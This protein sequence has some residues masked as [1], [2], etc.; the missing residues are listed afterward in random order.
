MIALSAGVWH[1][2]NQV[3]V[4]KAQPSIDLGKQAVQLAPLHGVPYWIVLSCPLY[5]LFSNARTSPHV[6]HILEHCV[7]LYILV[8]TV[9]TIKRTINPCAELNTVDYILPLN[10]LLNLAVCY[11]S[12]VPAQYT[13]GYLIATVIVAM[14]LRL[15]SPAHEI[16]TSAVINDMILCTLIFMIY[17]RDLNAFQSTT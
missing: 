12:I 17:K 11:L 5:L 2:N 16:A 6:H 14:W 8:L 10:M 7:S 3:R 15:A 1:I 13:Q 9:N 4:T